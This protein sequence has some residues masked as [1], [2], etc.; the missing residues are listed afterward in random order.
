MD[1]EWWVGRVRR[2]GRSMNREDRDRGAETRLTETTERTRKL[3]PETMWGVPEGWCWWSSDGDQRWRASAA[4]R[5][6]RDEV[7]EIWRLGG[8]EGF[9]SERSLYS[10]RSVIGPIANLKGQLKLIFSRVCLPVCVSD[11]H[12]YPSPLTDF[13]ET[14]SQRPCCDLVWPRP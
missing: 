13:D 9:V 10:M 3:I 6:N 12:F 11:R 2:C 7:V 4:M 1:G 8:C 14:W 5:L